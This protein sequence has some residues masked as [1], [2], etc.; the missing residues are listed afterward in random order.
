MVPTPEIVIWEITR[1]CNLSCRHCIV[2]ADRKGAGSEELSTDDA[3]DALRQL[4]DLGVRSVFFSGG[5]PFLR[6]D[7]AEIMR[8]GNAIARF[9]W[10]V[11]SNGTAL[12]PHHLEEMRPLGLESVQISL[13]GATAEQNETM[14]QGP[15]G[16]FDR[17]LAAVRLCRKGG[18]PIAVGMFLHPGNIDSFEE[19]IALASGEGVPTLRLSGFIPL[20][21]GARPEIQESMRYDFDQMTR[22]FAALAR[23]DPFRT[24]VTLAFDH[25]FGPT[26]GSF[27]C[28]AGVKSFYLSAEG[29]VYPCPSFTHADYR[30]G[31]VREHPLSEIWGDAHMRDFHCAPADLQGPCAQ[32]P[33]VSWCRGGCRGTTYAYTR[34]TR[35]SFPNCL[36]RYRRYLAARLGPDAVSLPAAPERGTGLHACVSGYYEGHAQRARWLLEHHPLSYLLWQST[37]RC[38]LRCAHCAVPAEG[39]VR[40]REMTTAQVKGVLDAF[41]ADF[42]VTRISA[43]AISGGEPALREDL[44]EVVSHAARLGFRVGLDSNGLLLG[45]KPELLDRLIEAGLSI[46]CFSVD[47]LEESHD[48]HRGV[49]CFRDVVSAIEH[50]A[51]RHPQVPIQ[52]VTMVTRR[53]L[54]EVPRIFTRLESLGVR[55]ARFGT[56]LPLGRAPR[57]PENFLQPRELRRLLA[58]IARRRAEHREGRTPLCV[59]FTDD[60]WCGRAVSSEG[61]EGRVRESPFMCSAGVTMATIYY[62]GR[63]GACMSIPEDLSVQGNLLEERPAEIWERFQR[64]R[65]RRWLQRDGCKD[66]GEWS[67]CLGGGMHERGRDGELIKCTWRTLQAA[68]LAEEGDLE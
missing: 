6:R 64:F 37:L 34:D 68:A 9:R 56:I 36:R 42:D 17:A 54:A 57:D 24:G 44:P 50:L 46:P 19:V 48:R 14:R 25:A 2:A 58:W 18:V 51:R 4:A 43:L 67:Y 59:E 22:F 7:L 33:D 1:R 15:K 65:D 63:M 16:A 31:N 35:A 12:R 61:L 30:I 38:N 60:G 8:R 27:C 45:R 40:G 41:S 11:A 3:A 21:R 10:S 55:F 53:T 5:E 49:P 39:W 29:H 32:C 52:T 62:D 26:D 28:T 23:H 47:G 13:D 20:G 66:C